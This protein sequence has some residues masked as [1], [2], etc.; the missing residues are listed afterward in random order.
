MAVSKRL[1]YEV[2]R[3]DNSTCQYCGRTAPEVKLT[4]DHV[5]P[6]ALGGRD[7]PSNL[8]TAC[9]PC[10]S[11]K[12]SAS[13]DATLVAKVAEDAARWAAAQRAVVSERLAELE[14]NAAVH[15]TFDRAWRRD[16]PRPADWRHS[17]DNFLAAGLPMAVLLECVTKTL[18]RPGVSP[19]GAFRYMCRLAW[20][21]VAT[22]REAIAA[23]LEEKTAGSIPAR[24]AAL[25]RHERDVL[26]VPAHDAGRTEL[27]EEILEF[28]GEEEVERLRI[29]GRSAAEEDGES[30]DPQNVTYRAAIAGLEELW[31]ASYQRNS[32][33]KAAL[34][35]LPEDERTRTTAEGKEH[36]EAL[37]GSV[38]DDLTVRFWVARQ[39]LRDVRATSNPEPVD[40]HD[41]WASPKAPF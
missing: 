35:C 3:R 34:D 19:D 16:L 31:S 14:R 9:E 33:V 12:T 41:P 7:E 2:L 6:E 5:V 17:V 20:D 11:G 39:I 21:E 24:V 28:F 4:I 32:L 15:D 1:R 26:E 18:G 36:L 8:V 10:N 25:T 30:T 29:R 40:P 38:E 23:R 13:P 37:T 27:A 22:I